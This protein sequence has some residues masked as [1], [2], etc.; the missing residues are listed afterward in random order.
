MSDRARRARAIL[1]MV[2][3]HMRASY[4]EPGALFWT[5][6]F[7]ILLS[8]V[9]GL[10]FR[11]RGPEPAL[12]AVVEGPGASEVAERL[13]GAK[14]IHATRLSS[15]E[16][17][18]ALR[19]SKLDLVITPTSGGPP[20]SVTY[21][22]DETRPESRLARS[23][24]D[25]VLQRSLGRK[26]AAEV[27]SELM[28]EIGSRYIDFLLPGLLG[29]GLMST[30]LWGI[31]FSLADM[32]AKKLLK[33]IIAT[34]MRRGD[35]LFSFLL[36]RIVLLCIELPPLLLFAKLLFGITVR[37]SVV[38]FGAA[39]ALG[40]LTFATMG[41]ALASRAENPQIVGGLINVVSFPMYLCSGVFFSAS[42]F[43]ER[44]QPALALLPL[45]ALNDALRA[46]MT[47]GAGFAQ[48]TR[49][50]LVL[51]V[52]LAVSFAAAV[53]LFKWR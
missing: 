8:V 25:D 35:F 13:Q 24:T 21:R 22:Y 19:T 50:L 28:T 27:R 12:V 16:A 26:D 46:V 6:G 47:D 4:R 2:S 40:A 1:A 38:A 23:I 37:G 29:L 51:A 36:V 20:L 49:P 7:P 30:G 52:W 5:Y 34:P 39:V 17:S 44:V 33:R 48:V 3:A 31:G 18:N 9:L 53:K 41:L 43:P 42:R 11:S 45:S 15:A 10:A 14:D 32:R